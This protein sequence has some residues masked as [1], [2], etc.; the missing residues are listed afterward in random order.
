VPS[1]GSSLLRSLHPADFSALEPHLKT[2]RAEK[3]AVLHEQGADICFTYFPSGGSIAAFEVLVQ[4]GK[5]V[6]TTL[7]GREGAV[8]GIVSHGYL[9]AFARASVLFPGEFLKIEI[10]KLEKA[11]AQSP[12]IGHLFTC[13]SD[14]LVAQLLQSSACNAVHSIEQRA[15]KWLRY[16]LDR[17][18][19]DEIRLTQEELANLLG[20]S[21]THMTR[22]LS[23]LK[24]CGIVDTRRGRFFVC[25]FERLQRMCCGCHDAVYHHF[26]TVLKGIYPGRER[27][28]G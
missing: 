26:E 5:T 17:T 25:D 16:A 3:G 12:A 6:E 10:A 23:R 19:G 20:V 27:A 7:I 18:G 21:R 11:K 28:V 24:V 1:L 15:A 2:V 14:C 22:V 9:P 8:G 13:Y 4:E